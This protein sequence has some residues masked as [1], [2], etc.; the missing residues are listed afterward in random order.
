V[1]SWTRS[2]DGYSGTFYLCPIAAT[3]SPARTDYRTR[4]Y[5]ISITFKPV[6]DP[7]ALP[8]RIASAAWVADRPPTPSCS[9]DGDGSRPPASIRTE[10]GVRPPPRASDLPQAKTGPLRHRC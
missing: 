4:F 5:K 10:G 7:A 3:T 9:P 2:G 1:T 6:T 8:R